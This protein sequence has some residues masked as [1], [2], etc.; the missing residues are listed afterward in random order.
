MIVSGGSID[1][2]FALERI[3]N[4]KPEVTIGV[5]KGAAFFY[6]NQM[7]PSLLVGDFDSVDAEI[8][9]HFRKSAET[10]IRE[11]QPEKD[12][13]DTEIAVQAAIESGVKKLWVLGATGTRF[14]HVLANMQLLKLA[15]DAK[16]EM[17]LLDPCNHI[18]L[19]KSPLILRKES[20]YGDYFSLFSFGG[21]VEGL[22]IQGAKYTLEDY[23]LNQNNSR[24]VSNELQEEE[25]IITWNAGELLVMET[26][27]EE[28]GR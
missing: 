7:S 1:D 18:Y 9:A 28:E 13:S 27:D 16:V 8:V 22:T 26:R 12:A 5:D 6:R 2:A 15:K 25:A 14:D 20:A 4:I 21:I 3:Q 24:C 23:I 11:F 19:P 17:H 10:E